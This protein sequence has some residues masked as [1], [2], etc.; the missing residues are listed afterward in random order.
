MKFNLKAKLVK[1]EALKKGTFSFL[2]DAGDLYKSIKPGQFINILVEGFTLRRPISI[3]EIKN[4]MLRIVFNVK[5]KGTKEM[6]NWQKGRYIDIVAPLG[7]GFS[8][9]NKNEKIL[10]V[11]GGIGLAPLLE[12]SKNYEFVKILA[13]FKSKEDIILKY[14]FEKYGEFIVCTQNGSFG[15][16][17]LVTDHVLKTIKNYGIEKIAA[18]GPMP[19]L[20]KIAHISKINNIACYVSLEQRMACGIG[21]CLGCAISTTKNNTKTNLY[22]CKDGPIFNSLK[23]WP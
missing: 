6:S 3:C 19:M 2:L 9:I 16:E 11:G 21:A 4:K 7:N 1:K 22:I 17:G 20:K 13:G 10:L 18:C 23:I 15:K 14:D 5:G 12:L 8:N